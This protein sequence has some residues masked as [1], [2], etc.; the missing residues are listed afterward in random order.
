M[1]VFDF[2][3]KKKL[4]TAI[5][6]EIFGINESFELPKVLLSKLMNESEKNKL[7]D[8]LLQYDFDYKNDCLRDYFQENNTNRNALKQDYTPDCLCTLISRL[9]P[10]TKNIID[11]CSGTG[12]LTVS[13]DYN[14]INYQCE[15]LSQ[16]SIPILLLNLCIRNLKATVLQKNVLENKVEKVYKL[17][18]GEKYSN[19]TV[20]GGYEEQKVSCVISNPPYSLSWKPVTDERFTGYELAPK[21]KSD[22]AFVIDGLSRL[23]DNGKAFY[24][25]PHGVL[26]RGAAEGKIRKKLVDNNLIS[27]IIGVP[28]KLFL[29]TQIPVCIIVFDK[30][31]KDNKILFIDASKDFKK[32]GKQNLMTSEQIERIVETYRNRRTVNKFASLVNLRQIIENDYNLNIPRYVDN[33]EPEPLPPI[34]ETVKE[35]VNIDLQIQKQEREIA[36]MIQD[37]EFATP[38]L[39]EEYQNSIMPFLNYLDKNPL[40]E[41]NKNWIAYQSMVAIAEELQNEPSEVVKLYDVAEI[42]RVKKN[43]VYSKG[44]LYLQFSATDKTIRYLGKSSTLETKFGIIKPKGINSKYL[45]FIL[46]KELPNF[47]A[48]YLSGININPD[49]FKFMKFEIHTS[50]VAQAKVVKALE[51]A[52]LAELAVDKWKDFKKYHLGM[53][54]C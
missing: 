24:I 38:E 53:M 28:D 13:A 40:E 7:C 52:E 8:K 16:M 26:F 51:L 20:A 33:Y 41:V 39:E 18:Q 44:T 49:I 48:R 23:N 46:Q 42:E 37:F 4:D 5:I 35:L 47:L 32:N 45:Y 14:N 30:A 34:G 25:L 21:A 50:A 1:F 29:N 10:K 12:A 43:Q 54:F 36:E 31:K 9:M 15:E 2:R 22:Y 3:E 11:I 19:I 6:N 17:A 27:A